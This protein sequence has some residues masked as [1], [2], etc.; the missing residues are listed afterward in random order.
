VLLLLT[1]LLRRCEEI[2]GS[3]L[4]KGVLTARLFYV[5]FFVIPIVTESAVL[6]LP[7]RDIHV[8]G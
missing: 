5:T 4:K 6:E 3:S 1:R 2:G 8:T 7:A